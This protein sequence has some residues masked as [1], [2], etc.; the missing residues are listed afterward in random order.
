MTVEW[1]VF[2][3]AKK[4]GYKENK[5]DLSISGGRKPFP[6]RLRVVLSYFVQGKM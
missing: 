3:A 1:D 2:K 5:E 6:S 4:L